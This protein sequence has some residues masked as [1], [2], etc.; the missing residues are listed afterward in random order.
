MP[1]VHSGHC[2]MAIPTVVLGFV[3]VRIREEVGHRSSSVQ[4][5]GRRLITCFRDLGISQK[6]RLPICTLHCGSPL[7]SAPISSLPHLLSSLF[8][9][10]RR[11]GFCPLFSSFMSFYVSSSSVPFFILLRPF[12]SFHV[13]S[14]SVPFSSFYVLLCPFTSPQL[15]PF[16]VLLRSFMSLHV[17][18]S[19]VPSVCTFMSVLFLFVLSHLLSFISFFV[20][21]LRFCFLLCFSLL[22]SCGSGWL[23]S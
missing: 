15:C 7:L 3:N 19:F 22:V 12:M 18:S 13:S 6:S 4:T 9:L 8:V 2:S 23:P 20:S 21:F 17:S 11:L 16:F 5:T 14:S 10:L 1:S